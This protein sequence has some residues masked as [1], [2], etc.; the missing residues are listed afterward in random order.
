M[1]CLLVSRLTRLER[2]DAASSERITG[3]YQKMNG[4]GRAWQ[5]P[6]KKK[7]TEKEKV[8]QVRCRYNYRTGASTSWLLEKWEDP[9]DWAPKRHGRPQ[10]D[11]SHPAPINPRDTARFRHA[12]RKACS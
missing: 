10:N 3:E 9:S 6:V 7:K 2:K 11:D 1:G 8:D 5:A 12:L 4:H